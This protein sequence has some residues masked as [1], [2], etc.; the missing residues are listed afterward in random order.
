M[1]ATSMLTWNACPWPPATRAEEGTHHTSSPQTISTAPGKTINFHNGPTFFMVINAHKTGVR[2]RR[3][4]M[5][6]YG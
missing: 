5:I 4:D 2:L 3:K 6:A 1:D